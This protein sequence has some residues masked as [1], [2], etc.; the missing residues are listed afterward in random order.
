MKDDMI[1][2]TK[3]SIK[4]RLQFKLKCSVTIKYYEHSFYIELLQN[5][6]PVYRHIITDVPDKL[7]NSI[8]SGDMSNEV[9]V[10]F[11]KHLLSKYFK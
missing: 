8:T 7:N 4:R 11:R 10:A 5:Y 1:A 6:N 3:D 9:L 2:L